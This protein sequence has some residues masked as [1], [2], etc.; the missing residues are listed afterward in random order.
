MV[1]HGLLSASWAL[2]A[3]ASHGEGERPIQAA[4]IRFKAPL[5]PGN[6]AMVRAERNAETVT[7]AVTDTEEVIVTAN[8]TVTQ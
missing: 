2:Q 6:Q 3:A 5:L 7:V 8:V 4:K 1:G